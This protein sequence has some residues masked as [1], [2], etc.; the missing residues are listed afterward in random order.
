MGSFGEVALYFYA[1]IYFDVVFFLEVVMFDEGIYIN[2]LFYVWVP[3][4]NDYIYIDNHF[5]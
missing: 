3:L 1:G 5:I 4:Y 2:V